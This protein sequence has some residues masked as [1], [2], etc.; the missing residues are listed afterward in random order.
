MVP[1]FGN[2]QA[3]N[4]YAYAL[5]NP[6][7][8]NDPSGHCWGFASGLRGTFYATTCDNL[9]MALAI[10]TSP[11]ATVGQKVGA[12]NLYNAPQKL[13]HLLRWI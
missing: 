8:Y 7:V 10:A 3:L 5:N 1:D 12:G 4:R 2:P 9:D 11:D 6:V 13:D